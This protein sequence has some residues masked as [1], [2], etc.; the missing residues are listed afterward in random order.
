MR[1]INTSWAKVAGIL[2][3][4]AIVAGCEPTPEQAK[5]QIM[6]RG[7]PYS[8]EGLVQSLNENNKS[9]ALRF[10]IAD[11]DKKIVNTA[12]L[13]KAACADRPYSRRMECLYDNGVS[14]L[15]VKG[16]ADV[17]YTDEDGRNLA[18]VA[19]DHGQVDMLKFGLRQDVS[20]DD[21]TVVERAMSRMKNEFVKSK[22]KRY[23]EIAN[24][25]QVRWTGNRQLE[26][27][28]A[29]QEEK[30]KH[31]AIH[32]KPEPLDLTEAPQRKRTRLE[33]DTPKPAGFLGN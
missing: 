24:L 33:K 15:I 13:I 8:A 20:V 19:A 25:L 7:Y 5:Q 30:K 9:V 28:T 6:E 10:F 16:G 27:F 22:R 32:G 17:K 3:M 4:L 11:Q 26:I 18:T 1:W 14:Y 2:G 29:H 12:M 23:E 31:E 21:Y